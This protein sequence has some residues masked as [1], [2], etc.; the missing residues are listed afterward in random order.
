MLA[1]STLQRAVSL[2]RSVYAAAVMDRLVASSPPTRLTLPTAR[3]ERVVPLTVEQVQA[4]PDAMPARNRAMVITQ[5]GLGLRIGELLALRAQDVNF[6]G[7]TVRIEE[8]IAPGARV[9]ADVKTPTSRRTIP[10]PQVV[11][12][13]LAEHM[14]AFPPAADGSLFTTQRATVYWHRHYGTEIFRAAV[15]RVNAAAAEREAAR[16][17]GRPAGP[18]LPVLP[19]NTTSHDLRHHYASVL[20]FAGESVVAVAERLGHEN[21]AL[22]LAVYGHI[23]PTADETTRRAVDSAWSKTKITAPGRPA[24]RGRARRGRSEAR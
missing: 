1:P 5:A 2:L 12:E 19:E 10:L 16:K 4:L 13:A 15:G 7:R 11:A 23:M 22:V 8:Q 17:A 21:A 9:R 14:G 24:Q 18:P 6:L 3:R 20:L